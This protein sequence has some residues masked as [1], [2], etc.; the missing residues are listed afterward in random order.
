MFASAL[1]TAGVGPWLPFQMLGASW[2]G[3]GAGLLPRAR[4]KAE[5]AL[6]CVYGVISAYAFGML[7]NLWFWPFSAGG[8]RLDFV[9]GDSVFGNLHRFV[10]FSFATSSIGWDTGRAI[11]NVAAILLIG[12]TILATLRRSARRAAFGEVATFADA[13]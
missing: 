11:T 5:I 1:L 12:P 2:V 3:L 9:P 7:L 13:A 6:L 8:T 10:L 4:G